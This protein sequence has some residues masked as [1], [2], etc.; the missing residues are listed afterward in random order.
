METEFWTT[1]TDLLGKSNSER[2]HDSSRCREKKILQLLRH[3]KIPD[4]PWDDVTI[5]YFFGKL[6]A[7]DSNNF[8]GN[9]GVGEREGRVY[10]NLVAQRHYR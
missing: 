3:K 8:V 1:L 6:S 2:A 5:E 9:M 4:E 10:S 7:M